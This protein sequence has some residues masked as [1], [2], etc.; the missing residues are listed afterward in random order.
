MA[1]TMDLEYLHRER[2]L[3]IAEIHDAFKDVTREGGVSWSEAYAIDDYTYSVDDN[4]ILDEQRAK[5]RDMDTD[6]S[7]QELVDDPTWPPGPDFGGFSFLDAVG[8]RYYLAPMLIR[9]LRE[10]DRFDIE[11]R[12]TLSNGELRDYSL[13]QWS[14]L[15]ERQRRCI[16]RFVAFQ[17]DWDRLSGSVQPSRW[18]RAL[19]TYWAQY[20]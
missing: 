5:A 14:M 11:Y 6:I 17:R 18:Q 15:T 19:D 10:D 4:N 16:A 9:S 1:V 12:L 7:W 2:A 13:S 3:L 20:V 8:Y